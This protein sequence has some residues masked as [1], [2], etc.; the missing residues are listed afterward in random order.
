MAGLLDHLRDQTLHGA[1]DFRRFA[2]RGNVVDLAVGVVVGTAFG[3]IVSSLVA[4]ILMPPLGLIIG[5]VKFTHMKFVLKAATPS[6]PAVTINYGSFIQTCADFLIVALCI[7]LFVKALSRLAPPPKAAPPAQERLL[8]EIRD[9][10]RTMA[11]D[12][13]ASP[14]AEVPD[15]GRAN[16]A[17][18]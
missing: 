14:V 3:K 15:P 9:L 17:Q 4:D 12:G 10:L 7:Y 6:A 5:G 18:R 13:R 2:V 11:S 8:E 16:D 1:Q